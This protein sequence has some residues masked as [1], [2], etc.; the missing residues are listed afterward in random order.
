MTVAARAPQAPL[1]IGWR[2]GILA[3]VVLQFAIGHGA[4][5]RRSFDWDRSIVWSYATIP[6]LVLAALLIRK[7]ARVVS[8]FLHTL[9]IAAAKFAITAGI[10]MV[11][12]IARYGNEPVDA[13]PPSAAPVVSTGIAATSVA[14]TAQPLTISAGAVLSPAV[15]VARAGQPIVVTSSDGRLHSADVHRPDGTRIANVSVLGSGEPT[16]L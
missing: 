11:L 3:I 2:V 9:E 5:W 15:A 1:S 8:W 13:S 7:R 12:L 6:L 14:P 4:V 16:V 10:L